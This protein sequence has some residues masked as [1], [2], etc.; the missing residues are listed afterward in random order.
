MANIK[1]RINHDGNNIRCQC[2]NQTRKNSL[3]MFD[4]MVGQVY[5]RLCDECMEQL[6]H[7]SLKATC[8]VNGKLKDKSDIAVLRKRGAKRWEEKH[9]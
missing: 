7:K 8:I 4:V 9:S 1:M 5:I 6:F 2:C 3:E